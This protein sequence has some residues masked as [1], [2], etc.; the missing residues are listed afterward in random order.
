MQTILNG[1]GSALLK[2][3]FDV[4]QSSF[5]PVKLID[6]LEMQSLPTSYMI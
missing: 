4:Y 5:F 1:N 3:A 2:Y 6:E